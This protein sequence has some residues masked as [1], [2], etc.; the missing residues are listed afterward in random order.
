MNQSD[1]EP[2]RRSVADLLQ[3][4]RQGNPEAT[5]ELFRWS[6]DFLRDEAVCAIKPQLRVRVH[7][8]D[9]A[10]QVCLAA[11]KQLGDFQG[12]SEGEYAQWLR[13]I[14]QR[15]AQDIVRREQLAAKRSI[16]RE[17]PD[18]HA[19][20]QTADWQASPSRHAIRNEER[21]I[22]HQAIEQLPDGQRE[23][24]W[25]RHVEGLSLSQIVERLGKSEDAVM[26]LL[27]RGTDKLAGSLKA[28][29]R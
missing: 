18:N 28:R 20:R 15:D 5:G 23:V 14:L 19:L 29:K 2:S 1:A 12:L 26:G 27:R 22:L 21:E 13:K 25:M 11:F 24:V 7:E 6:R 9:L 17:V 3:L 8:S 16:D 10:Q 4:C